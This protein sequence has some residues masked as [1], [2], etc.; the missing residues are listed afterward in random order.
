MKLRPT[1]SALL[2]TPRSLRRP[3][4]LKLFWIVPFPLALSAALLGSI[5]VNGD[6]QTATEDQGSTATSSSPSTA[7]ARAQSAELERN[8]S[9]AIKLLKQ[10]LKQNPSDRELML[11]LGRAYL[12]IGEDG[13]AQRLF[14]NLLKTEPDNRN[15]MLELA[16]ARAYQGHYTE[17]D[18][19]YRRLLIQN[20]ADEAAAI[21]LTSNLLHQH[22]S[23][24][25]SGIANEALRYHPDSLRLL[26]YRDRI[27]R[28]LTGGEER[29]L[30]LPES[31]FSTEMDYVNDSA[32]NQTFW[33][34]ERL[35]VQLRPELT[36]DSHID[37]QILQSPEHPRQMV[38]IFD[39]TFRW[40][41]A[42][43]LGVSAGGGALRFD[44]GDVSAL[45]ETTVTGQPARHFVLGAG[46]SRIPV[47]PDAEA[48]EHRITAQGFDAVGLWSPASWHVTV[49]GARRHYSDGNLG[50]QETAEI[51]RQWNTS[52]MN[53]IAG[54]RYRH[55]GFSEDLANGYFS[56]D[57]YQN[58]QFTLGAVLHPGRRYRGEVMGRIG[59][60]SIASGASFRTAWEVRAR[61]QLVIGHWEL[62]LD[63]S[64]YHMAQFTGAFRADAA[65]F[66]FAYHF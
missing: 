12:S 31:L 66:E 52:V 13:K 32:G 26:E 35:E 9:G 24:E 51:L 45:Y 64:H 58:H 8:Y 34:S 22:R 1:I 3:T 6:C 37:Q 20:P 17:S 50:D 55:Y 49:R 46:F 59:G 7:L 36:S 27:A 28:G 16:R 65:R 18:D 4:Q 61:N 25:A 48:A 53:Y 23:S 10:G 63:Y 2:H 5:A 41:P 29:S 14:S 15:A 54:Y 62:G 43:R 42:E 11:E 47:I 39:Q 40:R 60:E 38:Q 33:T 30:P 19:L 44:N 56:P 21:G 57:N